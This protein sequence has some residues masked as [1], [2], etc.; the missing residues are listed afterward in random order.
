MVPLRTNYWCQSLLCF[1]ETS[2]QLKLRIKKVQKLTP[3]NSKSRKKSSCQSRF[4]ICKEVRP[5]IVWVACLECLEE[6]PRA[7]YSLEVEAWEVEAKAKAHRT[8]VY[9]I[10][11]Y[12]QQKEA[13]IY[14]SGEVVHSNQRLALP[15]LVPS[16]LTIR[17]RHLNVRLVKHQQT[18]AF[19]YQTNQI[20]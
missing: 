8:L 1:L 17:N 7:I 20:H 10:S 12:S 6:N 18:C 11:Q 9:Q 4:A 3:L 2:N 16:F 14:R 15:I 19:S 5:T 13:I